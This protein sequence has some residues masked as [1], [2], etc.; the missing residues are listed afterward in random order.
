MVKDAR[1]DWESTTFTLNEILSPFLYIS[2]IGVW[3]IVR[4]GFVLSI[5]IKI[6]EAPFWEYLF[7]NW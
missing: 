5:L 7:V 1:P 4:P 2:F 6:F 3:V